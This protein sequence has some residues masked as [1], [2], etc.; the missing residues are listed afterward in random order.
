MSPHWSTKRRTASGSSSA[1]SDISVITE[2]S[3]TT[4]QKSRPAPRKD[5]GLLSVLTWLVSRPRGADAPEGALLPHEVP[6]ADVHAVVAQDGVG[7]R[8][9]KIEVRERELRQIVQPLE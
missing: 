5:A 4:G 7:H 6:L 3:D 2:I 9:V 1:T 8:C